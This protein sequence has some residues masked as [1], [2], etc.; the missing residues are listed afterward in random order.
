M[1]SYLRR[2]SSLCALAIFMS[3]VAASPAGATTL[4]NF[5]VALDRPPYVSAN[6][7]RVDYDFFDATTS[8][9]I[10]LMDGA[11]ELARASVPIGSAYTAVTSAALE[12]GDRVEIFKPGI[13]AGPPAVA[14]V[15]QYEIPLV[16]IAGAPGGA[17][18]SG[19]A[20]DGTL[21]RISVGTGCDTNAYS[22]LP[23]A[24]V[25]GAFSVAV[26][27]LAAGADLTLR[28]FSG[29]GDYTQLRSRVPGETPC[30]SASATPFPE[31]P[32][33]DPAAATP[34]SV[35]VYNLRP[36]VA[37]DSRLVWR[38]G[39]TVIGDTT[40]VGG[41]QFT[42]TSATQPI[43]GDV[44][45]V[46]RPQTALAPSRSV[47]IPD[48]SATVDTGASLVAL[49]SPSVS[50]L[51]T[52]YATDAGPS[53]RS[54]ERSFLSLPAGRTV[55][56][57][58]VSQGDQRPFKMRPGGRAF[59]NWA[60]PDWGIRYDVTASPGDLVS[61]AVSAKFKSKLRLAKIKK[62][63]AVRV[64]S[65]EI[66]T[67]TARL[68]VA[69][70]LPGKGHPKTKPGKRTITFAT[71]KLSLGPGSRTVKLKLSK[72]GLRALKQLRGAG[73]SMRAV[74]AALNLNVADPSGN[75]TSV[76]R[77]MKLVVK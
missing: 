33:I 47:T 64:S 48:V 18:V 28:V 14:P 55:V 65:S 13:P 36:S 26:P 2:C 15:D 3:V 20:P 24:A 67:G 61:P 1:L 11:T 70:R 23:V 59:V 41:T 66:A 21:A 57:Y 77:T 50:G 75:V 58:N 53:Q 7:A 5:T 35:R 60:S 30:F 63:I 6:T 46:Y 76:T 17:S 52:V 71:A 73:K 25:G 32:T 19:S 45:E 51:V 43:P 29:T 39:A 40:N 34:Y 74:K 10:R 16:A 49:S 68:L 12:P 42:T 62:S 72:A 38:R 9:T 31:Q 37:N 27:P 44:I 69:E 56:D 22:T 4:G 8:T 54:S